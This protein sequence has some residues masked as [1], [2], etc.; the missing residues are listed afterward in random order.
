MRE[1]DTRGKGGDSSSVPVETVLLKA[2]PLAEKIKADVSSRVLRIKK[3]KQITPRLIALLIGRDPVSRVYVRLKQSDCAEVGIDSKV[4]DLSGIATDEIVESVLKTI[5]RLNSDPSVHGII[6]QMP[7]DGQVSE[8][9]VFEALNP[10]K[11]VDG[12]TP[13]RLGKLMRKEYSLESSLLPCTPKGIVS[14]L[15][16]YGV[17]VEGA[18]ALI[19][20]RSSLVSEPLRKMLQDLNATATCVHTRTK[21]IHEKI[22]NA[23]IV[24]AASGRPPEIY[25]SSGIRVVGD[26]VKEGSTVVSVGVR[27]D[28]Q[29]GKMLFDVDTNSLMGRCSFLTP[30]IGGVGPMTRLTLLQNTIIAA[31]LQLG[32]SSVSA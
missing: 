16:Y 3:E 23:D 14:L 4:I 30:N 28:P 32:V 18:D 6:P 26:M 15:L 7:F 8:E 24:V 10:E 25:G 19:I 31:E 27:Q 11:D 17:E 21:G 1:E 22:R 29:T 13:Y 12:L 5:E 20:G 2:N 9:Q